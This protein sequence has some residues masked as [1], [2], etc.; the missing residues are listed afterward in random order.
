MTVGVCVVDWDDAHPMYAGGLVGC[1][2]ARRR[3]A[4]CMRERTP[5]FW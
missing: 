4:S 3:S 5:Y 1:Q 2:P